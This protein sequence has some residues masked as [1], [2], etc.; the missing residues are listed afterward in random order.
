MKR[1]IIIFLAGLLLVLAACAPVPPA[2]QGDGAPETPIEVTE[3]PEQEPEAP[4]DSGDVISEE[5][6]TP[7]SEAEKRQLPWDTDPEALIISA[8]FCC[9]F[10]PQL[11]LTNYI[12]DAQVW[13][14]GRVVWVEQSDDGS[15]R[16]LEGHIDL[17][18]L[19]LLLNRIKDAGFF[20]WDEY[21]SNPQVAD[22]ADKCINVNL[23]EGEKS[24]CEYYEGAPAAF[25][26]L[27]ALLSE[28][29]GAPDGE[30]Y[31]PESGF[32]TVI[33]LGSD[34]PTESVDAM[35]NWDA[36][37]LGISLS[38]V[39]DEGGAWVSGTT[40]EAAWQVVNQRPWNPLVQEGDSFYMLGLQVPNLSMVPPT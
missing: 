8:T 7:L 16:V 12:P 34:V 13:G 37:G 28:G 26:E 4:V 15:R 3:Q 2:S 33:P 20:E 6:V 22:F 5:E 17:G 25:H 38:V 30:D 21:Y 29:A 23:L 9:G 11:A 36:P 18:E 27:Y 1:L 24:V 32:L 10:A 14:D 39:E 35:L 19:E 31:A 40:L